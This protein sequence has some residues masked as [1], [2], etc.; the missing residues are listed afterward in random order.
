MT[1]ATGTNSSPAELSE[2]TGNTSVSTRVNINELTLQAVACLHRARASHT[3]VTV[4]IYFQLL[5][6]CP[7]VEVPLKVVSSDWLSLQHDETTT[8]THSTGRSVGLAFFLQR[9]PPLSNC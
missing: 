4:R 3:V 8:D 7:S 5:C 1:T 2:A 6:V 9:V